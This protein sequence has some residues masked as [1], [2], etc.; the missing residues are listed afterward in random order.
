MSSRETILA[1]IKGRAVKVR[2]DKVIV[3]EWDG[4][5]IWFRAC[6]NAERSTWEAGNVRSSSDGRKRTLTVEDSRA[7]FLVV[8]CQAENGEAL[9]TADDVAWLQ[10]EDAAAIDRIFDAASKFSGIVEREE[11]EKNLKTTPPNS[12]S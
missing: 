10:S 8:V 3:P 4:A 11:E 12:S 1:K 7:R 6:T 5:E 9:W 2:R